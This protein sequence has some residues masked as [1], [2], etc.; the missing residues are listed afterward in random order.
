MND[1]KKAVACCGNLIFVDEEEQT[2]HFTHSSVKQYLLSDALDESLQSYEID[3]EEAD[4]DIGAVCVTYL[5][6]SVFDTQ[7]APKAINRI[8]FAKVPST[9]LAKALPLSESANKIA[10]RLLRG[11][12]KSIQATH[13]VLAEVSGNSGALR[14]KNVVDQ[15]PFRQY[16]KQHWLTHTK[17][18]GP[19]STELR[20]MW[21]KLLDEAGWRDTLS[22]VP[23]AFEDWELRPPDVVDWT[24]KENHFELAQYIIAFGKTT[25][26]L[27][28]IRCAAYRGSERLMKTIASASVTPDLSGVICLASAA[29]DGRLLGFGQLGASLSPFALSAA[30]VA[31]ARGGHPDTVWRLLWEL[32][33]WETGVHQYEDGYMLALRVAADWGHKAVV[34]RLLQ[35][36]T[37][38]NVG[39]ARRYALEAAAAAGQSSVVEQILQRGGEIESDEEALAGSR[40]PLVSA[41]AQ[42]HLDIVGQFLTYEGYVSTTDSRGSAFDVANRNGRK[43]VVGRLR[44]VALTI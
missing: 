28:L 18:I 27:D 36:S 41:A 22:G 40:S 16:A 20:Q 12:D 43:E 15:F 29:R 13:Q 6:F 10:L 23:W 8:D 19:T 25:T 21:R 32:E 30:L 38:D 11:H 1:M 4:A 3:L 14:S 35:K 17:W 39:R 31:A 44:G 37:N 42:G 7:V 26:A 34:E 33:Q 24:L 9:V 5:N 2:V